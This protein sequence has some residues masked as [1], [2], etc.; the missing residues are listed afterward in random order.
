MLPDAWA[1]L[2]PVRSP[3]AW[4]LVWLPLQGPHLPRWRTYGF[5][6]A[7]L[8]STYKAPNAR[9]RKVP[10]SPA[11]SP[12]QTFRLAPCIF[13]VHAEPVRSF[14]SSQQIKA[15]WSLLLW[16]QAVA[17]SEDL[18][19][20]R[21]PANMVRPCADGFVMLLCISSMFQSSALRTICFHDAVME[22]AVRKGPKSEE[23]GVRRFGVTSMVVINY[24]L[25]RAS[26]LFSTLQ[27]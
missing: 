11:S 3:S 26:E 16:T 15:A 24:M 4:L 1:V 25:Y 5:T 20:E 6:P 12:G 23:D 18:R 17:F 14:E 9:I 13:L 7:G 10:A 22:V 19:L 2:C 8:F 27:F 21:N